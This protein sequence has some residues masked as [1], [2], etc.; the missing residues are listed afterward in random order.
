MSGQALSCL[1]SFTRRRDS[2]SLSSFPMPAV[3]RFSSFC[4]LIGSIAMSAIIAVIVPF[5]S[6]IVMIHARQG[7]FSALSKLCL[8]LY[9]KSDGKTIETKWICRSIR[10]LHLLK[11]I[12]ESGSESLPL[13]TRYRRE[14]DSADAIDIG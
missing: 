12:T 9:S 10:I 11:R 14:V 1:A 3:A 6:L 7:Y 4:P 2:S 8:E 5:I 13:H